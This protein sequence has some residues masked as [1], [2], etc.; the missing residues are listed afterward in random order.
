MYV[1]SVVQ[2]K[3]DLQEI[4]MLSSRWPNLNRLLKELDNRFTKV[5]RLSSESLFCISNDLYMN[6]LHYMYTFCYTKRK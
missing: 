5:N 3:Q 4:V 1:K 6:L 2:S